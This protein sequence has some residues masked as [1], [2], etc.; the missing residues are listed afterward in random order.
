ME[1]ED[2]DVT[3]LPPERFAGVLE[4]DAYKRFADGVARSRELLDGRT[5]GTSTRPRGAAGSPRCCGR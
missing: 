2:V 1:L 3:T 4:P 5:S